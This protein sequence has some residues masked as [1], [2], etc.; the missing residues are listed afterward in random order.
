MNKPFDMKKQNSKK[1][2]N[3]KMDQSPINQ[4]GELK[5]SSQFQTECH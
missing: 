4:G 1:K 5:K 3:T 2:N